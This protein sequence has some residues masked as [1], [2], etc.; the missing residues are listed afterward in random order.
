[1]EQAGETQAK[2]KE[3]AAGGDEMGKE[4]KKLKVLVAVD[5]S[6]GSLYALSWFLDHLFFTQDGEVDQIFLIHVQQPFQPFVYPSGPSVF[7][8]TSVI[9]SVRKAQK[10]NSE[11]LIARAVQICRNK[12][13]EI[14]V[15][16]VITDGEPK[17][18]ICHAIEQM[19]ID[20]AV[21]GSRGLGTFKRAFLGSVSDYCAHHAKCPILI[22]KPPQK[23]HQ[24][25][26]HP[27][28]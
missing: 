1:M 15:Q 24:Q 5:E 12:L 23:L 26:V 2:D 21:V 25:E 3:V 20:L 8:T 14:K 10:Q 6:E 27:H 19:N 11:A 4:I 16:T 17:D 7:A 18:V 28:Q 13:K 9:D 22:V